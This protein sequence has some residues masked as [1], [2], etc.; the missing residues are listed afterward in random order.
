[1]FTHWLTAAVLLAS[2]A[3]CL[4]IQSYAPY[5]PQRWLRTLRRAGWGALVGGPVGVGAVRLAL[6]P[7]QHGWWELPANTE[8]LYRLGLAAGALLG[9][10][11]MAMLSRLEFGDALRTGAA[12]VA[13]YVVGVCIGA[14]L[15]GRLYEYM[16]LDAWGSPLEYR[17]HVQHKLGQLYLLSTLGIGA[18]FTR[19]YTARVIGKTE[20]VPPWDA[21]LVF[22]DSMEAELDFEP[23]PEEG[24]VHA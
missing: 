1:M 7:G 11:A 12:A 10:S 3:G 21:E 2:A 16:M 5:M 13:P 20:A 14:W 18:A 9:A 19:R 15:G 22:W 8:F 17:V 4:Y 23:E 6:G 24:E